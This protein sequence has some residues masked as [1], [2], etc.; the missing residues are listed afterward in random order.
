MAFRAFLTARTS[1][2]VG[3]LVSARRSPSL[4]LPMSLTSAAPM[5]QRGHRHWPMF[6]MFAIRTLHTIVSPVGGAI[7]TVDILLR[8][9]RRIAVE[10]GED[11]TGDSIG[12][13]NRNP[14]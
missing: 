5:L 12:E 13:L 2:V 4:A 7:E 9:I 14:M 10:P 1:R 6:L 8:I 11:T 3:F